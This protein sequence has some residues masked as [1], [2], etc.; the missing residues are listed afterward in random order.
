M[1][2]LHNTGLGWY[3]SLVTSSRAPSPELPLGVHRV[4]MG[5][6]GAA[7]LLWWGAVEILVPGTFNPLGSRLATVAACWLL[8]GATF[9]SPAIARQSGRA[10]TVCLW[11]VTTHY[12]Y[13]VVRNHA[14]INWVVGAYI[15]LIPVNACFTT[16]SDLLFYSAGVLALSLGVG[17]NDPAPFRMTFI[18]GVVTIQAFAFLNLRS[19]LK[20]LEA[21]LRDKLHSESS[22]RA[23]RIREEFL[24]IISHELKTPL[25]N[26]KIQT[27]MAKRGFARGDL[28]AL[29]PDRARR[30]VEQTDRQ[31]DRLNRLVDEMLDVSRIAT[32]KLQMEPDRFDLAGLVR[33]VAEAFETTA[34][35]SGSR[36][37]LDV[38]DGH[39]IYADRFRMEQVISN[40]LSNAIKYGRGKPIRIGIATTGTRGQ[41]TLLSFEDQGAGVAPEDQAR[42]F[43]RFERAVSSHKISG[44]GLGLYISKHIVDAHGGRI[45]VVSEPGRGARFSVVLPT[46]FSASG[47]P[48]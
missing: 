44:L 15:L 18:P 32:G 8:L 23:L 28:S 47:G 42:I 10:V 38:P 34:A 16:A 37:D 43:L 2:N 35:E 9:L 26:I 48:A 5:A 27:E 36:L 41:D 31:A 39:Q 12:F 25:T 13:L 3:V 33:E 14:D 46:A 22:E 24:S 45:E 17:I 19:R 4:L 40:L 20:L 29:S 6:A 1:R 21:S 30:F 11:L 7:Y